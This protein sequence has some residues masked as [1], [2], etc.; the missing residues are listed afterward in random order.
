MPKVGGWIALLRILSPIVFVAGAAI[1]LWN[2]RIVLLGQRRWWAKL[3]AAILAASSVA[4][5]WAALA[6]HLISFRTGF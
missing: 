6:F 4:L 3:W 5:L 2:V 1:A